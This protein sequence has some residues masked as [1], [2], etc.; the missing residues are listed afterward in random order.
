[1]NDKNKISYFL[2]LCV[3]S[4]AFSSC[5]K[6]GLDDLPAF[7]EAQIANVFVEYRYKNPNDKWID[8]SAIIEYLNLEVSKQIV[9]SE[10]SN[11]DLDSVIV[12]VRVPDASGTFTEE[13]R[14]KV[15]LT[16]IVVYMNIST[17]ATIKPLGDS[18]ELGTLGDFSSPRKYR[19]T[20]ADGVT[21]RDWVVAI[22]PLVY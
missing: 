1:M 3:F 20:A 6:S 10:A 19:I 9:L 17:A 12:T 7:D 15:K 14:Q 21:C 18:P 22:K 11:A 2:L 16:N 8:S 13:E 5:L 4:V